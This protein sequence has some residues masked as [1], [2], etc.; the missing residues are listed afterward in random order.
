R[1]A[2]LPEALKDGNPL[3]IARLVDGVGTRAAID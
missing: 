3:G 1:D 2:W